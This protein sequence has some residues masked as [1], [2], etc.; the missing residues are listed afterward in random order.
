MEMFEIRIVVAFDA[1]FDAERAAEM[2]TA[3]LYGPTSFL[4]SAE[5]VETAGYTT[6]GVSE[7]TAQRILEMSEDRTEVEH[8]V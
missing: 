8:A 7:E 5:G 2:L 1:D 6:H 4:E 3:A